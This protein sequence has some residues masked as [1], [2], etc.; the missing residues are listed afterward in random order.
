L[1]FR[2]ILFPV[3]GMAMLIASLVICAGLCPENIQVD[4]VKLS[5]RRE[6][7]DTLR[8]TIYY[9]RND[10]LIV[11]VRRPVDQWMEVRGRELSLYYPAD[12][13][14]F[15]FLAG[16]P[17]TLP[18]VELF[19]SA[20]DPDCGLS[21]LGYVLKDHDQKGDT[22]RTIWEP[23]STRHAGPLRLR[24]NMRDRRLIETVWEEKPGR[25]ITHSLFS[26]H[27]EHDRIFFPMKVVTDYIENGDSLRDEVV[28]H[29]PRF[30][31]T[32]PDS[33]LAFRIPDDAPT[34]TV[35]W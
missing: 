33:I 7:V 9:H 15:R 34:D 10:F 22:L 17:V 1:R 14:V 29:D 6:R 30:D 18:I 35:R 12:R 4:F 2:G 19:L 25:A 3:F 16:P 5:T 28:Y 26:G 20:V 8:G 27:V 24:L 13:R 31:H 23:G 11:H 21:A 32:L